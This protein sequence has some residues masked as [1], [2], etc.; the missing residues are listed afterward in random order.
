MRL[1]CGGLVREALALAALRAHHLHAGVRRREQ[2]LEILQEIL[3]KHI[4][5]RLDL[6]PRLLHV[7]S[8]ADGLNSSR[9]SVRRAVSQRQEKLPAHL[10]IHRDRGACP[11]R[12]ELL[13]VLP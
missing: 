9:A 10:S 2:F 11:N 5:L 12:K 6:L 7:Q 13:N 8:Y 1:K 3:L 4:L